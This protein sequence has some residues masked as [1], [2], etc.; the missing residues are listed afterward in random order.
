MKRPLS[1]RLT[2][3]RNA[4]S[5]AVTM[6]VL[7]SARPALAAPAADRGA[8]CSVSV[9]AIAFGAYDSFSPLPLDSTGVIE[10]DCP[11]GRATIAL[12]TGQSGTFTPRALSGPGGERLSYNL[13]LDATRAVVWGD[14]TGGTVTAP[15]STDRGR[16]LTVYARV[17]AGQDVS[18]GTYADTI[19]LTVDF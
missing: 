8:P 4:T 15:F 19:V 10:L 7:L 12:G 9:G 16:R 14:G 18:A 5:L 3:A 2:R 6:C 17:F 11:P 13:Y 1:Q